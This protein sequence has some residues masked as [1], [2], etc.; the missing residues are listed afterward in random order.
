MIQNSIFDA[1]SLPA[2][3][4]PV[5]LFCLLMHLS[6]NINPLAFYSES[7]S[8]KLRKK[9]SEP[10]QWKQS[11][12]CQL[13]L[14][15]PGKALVAHTSVHWTPSVLPP[16]AAMWPQFKW[17]Q[18][19]GVSD[20]QELRLCL[21]NLPARLA[22]LCPPGGMPPFPVAAAIPKAAHPESTG[23]LPSWAMWVPGVGLT[24]HPAMQGLCRD[25]LWFLQPQRRG[26]MSIKEQD[27]ALWN[28]KLLIHK[29]THRHRC[30]CPVPHR[31]SRGK[32]SMT[33]HLHIYSLHRVLSV[34][35]SCSGKERNAN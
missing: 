20:T 21:P 27:L 12:R 4:F 10:H 2:F 17:N 5:L 15:C 7:I 9:N 25:Q 26:S 18:H 11:G 8:L 28:E 29:M 34:Q 33:T 1:W 24:S 23:C 32:T 16:R 19:W 31:G 13:H 14:L 22:H 3:P 35:F 6:D 30:E